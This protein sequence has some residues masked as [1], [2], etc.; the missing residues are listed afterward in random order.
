MISLLQN[1]VEAERFAHI[2]NFIKT[3]PLP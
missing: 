1:R 3:C 2:R